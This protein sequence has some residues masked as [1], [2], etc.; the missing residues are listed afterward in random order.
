MCGEVKSVSEFYQRRKH[1]SGEYYEKCKDCS[2]TRGR[3]YYHQN[4]ERQ[5][6]LALL[7]KDRYKEERRKWLEKIKDRPCIDCGVKYP[8]YIM[9]F[10]H[11]DGV[12]KIASISWLALHNTSNLEVIKLEIAKCEL[13]CA[14]CHRQR[15][16][17]RLKKIKSAA[18][19]KVVKAGV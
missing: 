5:L 2:K 4:H 14:N 15:T 10:D 18:V 1:R 6:R 7:R 12:V 9:D 13:V 16:H 8:P 19:A 3:N 17:D 11:K